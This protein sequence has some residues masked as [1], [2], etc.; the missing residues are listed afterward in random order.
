[1]LNTLR[2]VRV[3]DLTRMLA[4][5]FATM[6]L[7]DLGAEVI[8]IERP[9]VGDDIRG[10]GPH[11]LEGESV[12]FLSVNRNKRS[13][14]LDLARPEGQ[15]VLRDLVGRCDV[16]IEN[17][18]YGVAE[19]LGL[20]HDALRA[21]HPRLITCGMT[22]FGRSGPDRA[23]PA[24]DLTLQ[25]RAGVMGLTGH[26]DGRPARC[27]AP[28]GDLTG[29]LYAVIAIAA[30]LYEREKTGRGQCIDLGLLDC[31]VSLLTYALS[32]QVMAHDPMGPQGS[33][34]ADATP[35]QSL[36]ARDGELTVAVFT[37]TFWPGFCR[38]IEL[39]EWADD[40][41]LKGRLYRRQRRP[42]LIAAV[43]AQLATQPRRYWLERLYAEGVPA[44]PVQSLEE[45]AADPQVRARGMLNA[46]EHPT[47]GPFVAP[48]NPLRWM[49]EGD[50]RPDRA[51]PQLGADTDALL[52]ELLGYS[53]AQIAA[54]RR[55][56]APAESD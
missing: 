32:N 33:G 38:A 31:Q 45:V 39:P 13:M 47:V 18:R 14:A 54:L 41:L 50:A 15:A 10:V 43:E 4:G 16:L 51:A 48:G 37:D 19:R 52:R 42:E 12:Y 8:K 23:L 7:G 21:Q 55:A 3:L 34:H 24:F 44:A 53:D 6:I 9:G 40:P 20:D 22:A 35:Y 2:G 17:F 1:M 28:I 46:V 36:R 49:G 25:A 56:Q 30:A 26:R 5:P 29:G 11:F 27:G